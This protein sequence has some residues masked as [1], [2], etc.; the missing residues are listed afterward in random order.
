VAPLKKRIRPLYPIAVTYFLDNFGLA[1]IF[2]IFTPLF[3]NPQFAVVDPAASAFERSALLGI[4][5]ACFPFAQFFSSPIIGELSDRW[6][7]KSIL[8]FTI[9]GTSLGYLITGWAILW[10]G[11]I[12]ILIG[13]LI[14]GLFAGNLTVCLAAAADISQGEKARAKN[15]GLLGSAGG[16]SFVLAI[17]MGGT[18]GSYNPSF[19]FWV[20]TVLAWLNTLFVINFFPESHPTRAPKKLRLLQSVHNVMGALKTETNARVYFIFFFF[21]IAWTASMQFLPTFFIQRYHVSTHILTVVFI[22]I[23]A[24]WA[25]AN[26]VINPFCARFIHPPK[27]LVV[28]LIGLG[29]FLIT[30]PFTHTLFSSQFVF[31]GAVLMGAL[32]WSN[33]LTTV[34]LTASAEGQGSVLGI[35]RS[36]GSIG[37]IIGPT[38]GGLLAGIHVNLVYFF[39]ACASFCAVF[40]IFSIKKFLAKRHLSD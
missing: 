21:L 32:A 34:S 15:F 13:R 27:T 6:G 23:G 17:L 37:T 24:I 9:F 26:L 30:M 22:G 38:I 18:L 5:I 2:P 20:M 16:L 10:G 7:R 33:A 25:L 4:A 40:V 12:P 36:V 8:T 3:L 28:C 19:P 29:V 1:I 31:Y 35:N 39:T 11:I 14:T